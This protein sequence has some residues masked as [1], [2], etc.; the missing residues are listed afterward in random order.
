M[1]RTK[2]ILL[3]AAM[4][5]AHLF[6]A[7]DAQAGP[8]LDWLRGRRSSCNTCQPQPA[9]NYYGTQ[10]PVTTA[11]YPP[12]AQNA[13]GLQPGQCMKTCQQ[14]CSRTVVNYVPY[15]AYR[16]SWKRVPVTTYKPVTNSDPC[17]GCSVT[18]MRPCTTYTYQMQRVPYT[19]QRPVYRT[20]TY[21]VPV[22]TITNDCAT[23]GCNTGCNTCGTGYQGAPVQ[24]FAPTPT[25]APA[26]TT[27]GSSFETP[28]FPGTP[29]DS[30][31]SISGTQ[32]R[33]QTPGGTLSTTARY[34]TVGRARTSQRPQVSIP[35]NLKRE[36]NRSASASPVQRDWNYS[37]VRL[38][39]YSQ[40]VATERVTVRSLQK[41]RPAR[42][43][44]RQV[45][46]FWN[47][48]K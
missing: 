46:S 30:A 43:Q 37:P 20:E 31:P 10:A 18:C 23:G 9:Y 12:A 24:G 25:L 29:A 48:V 15:T 39:S 21:K 47:D 17:T 33:I 34:N 41:Q 35:Q 44:E 16:T 38:A 36:I 27:S 22:T 14:T 26:P 40:P 42:S 45:N 7:S 6:A 8:L 19:T 3:G 28:T 32:S 1:I 4:L 2:T 13:Y 11:Q 5:A